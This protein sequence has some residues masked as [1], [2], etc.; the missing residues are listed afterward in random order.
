MRRSPVDARGLVAAVFVAAVFVV[1]CAGNK[2]AP[3]PAPADDGPSTQPADPQGTGADATGPSAA[4]SSAHRSVQLAAIQ[5]DKSGPSGQKGPMSKYPQ[6]KKGGVVDDLHGSKI[7]DP[8]RWLEDADA[9]DTKA[10]VTEQNKLTFGWLEKIPARGALKTRLTE[11]W[12]YERFAPPFIE[13]KGGDRRTYFWKNDGLQ[14][15]AVLYVVDA[16][17]VGSGTS[18]K[19]GSKQEPRVL[20]DPNALSSDGTVALAGMAISDDG[21]RMAYA[22]STGGSDW[23]EW[24]VKDIASGKDSDDLVKWSKFSGASWTPDNK[25]FFYARYPEP[26]KGGDLEQANYFHKIYYHVIGESQDKDKLVYEDK[27]H[28]T[29]G[30]A[31]TVSEDGKYLI[32]SVW[33][34][35]DR[36]NRMYF[37][38]LAPKLPATPGV[39]TNDGGPVQKLFDAF[40]AS[41][42]FVGNVGT[43]FFIQTDKDAPRQRLVSV[44]VKG[45]KAPEP[46]LKEIIAQPPKDK[47]EAVGMLGGGFLV[48]KLQNAHDVVEFYDLKG[49]KIRDLPL[50]SIGTTGGF[51]GKFKDTDTYYSFTSFTYPTVIYRL[52]V[53]SGVSTM[54]KQPT[55]KF[56]PSAY[57]TKQVF[58]KSTDGTDIPMFIVHKKGLA[59][60]GNNPTYLYGYGGFNISLTPS[61]S[62]AL[63]A[64]LERGGVYAQPSLRG[65][66]EFGE[67]WH[68]AGMLKKK[69]N[70]FDDFSS[71]ARWLI[72]QKITQPK[73]LGIGG[74][75]NGGLLCGASINQH[76][77]LFGAGVCMV[78]VMDM[79]RFHKFTIGHAWV[80]EY[81]SSDDKD[82]LP[83][84]LTYSPL[85][86][87]KKGASYPPVLVTTADH[88]DR[89]VPAHSF[90]YV[91]ALQEAQ[92]GDAP[93]LIRID[94]KAGH[95]AGKPTTKVIEEAADRWAFLLAA[96]GAEPMPPL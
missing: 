36:R 94:V 38:E 82:M 96:L 66:G 16:A 61:F 7:A 85:H 30:F 55:V 44:D 10:W 81:G 88:D 95:G 20:L 19:K 17:D 63:V 47:I 91:A 46:K 24:R 72:D 34:G 70:V 59:Y 93:V 23:M 1:A 9:D 69:Q 31:P 43:T 15:Q 89:V 40:D 45:L 25:G 58:Y 26:E 76:P 64:W 35:T 60:D 80:S 41:Y 83:T 75:S 4:A 57:E 71:A 92:G 67:E 8:Y 6:S 90:K 49:K 3:E 65:G 22:L 74:G 56:D 86:N 48:K 78:G 79:L 18:S 68:E 62:P 39:W 27:E 2:P 87:L 50:P 73:K 13:G 42:G 28:K 77:E 37:K 53:K 14:N 54:W 5:N 11:L 33:D 84:L 52:D 21:K 51:S 12:N 29:W 32:I